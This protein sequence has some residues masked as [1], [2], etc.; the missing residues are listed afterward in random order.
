MGAQRRGQVAVVSGFWPYLPRALRA[1]VAVNDFGSRAV[2]IM[3]RQ[4]NSGQSTFWPGFRL[5]EVG[6]GRCRAPKIAGA[7]F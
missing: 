1:K 3:I 6:Q 2:P 4:N 5:V 7:E